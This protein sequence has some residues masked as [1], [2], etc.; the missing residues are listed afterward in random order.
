MMTRTVI[1]PSVYAGCPAFR[2][3]PD[4]GSEAEDLMHRTGF[5]PGSLMCNTTIQDTVAI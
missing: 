2:N 3:S 5:Q 4:R 1:W